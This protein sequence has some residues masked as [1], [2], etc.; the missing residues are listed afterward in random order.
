MSV[1]RWTTHGS[2][3][4]FSEEE[5]EK[6][7]EKEKG[8]A[9]MDASAGSAQQRASESASESERVLTGENPDTRQAQTI[10]TPPE[11]ADSTA[12]PEQQMADSTV[13]P[14]QQM[15]DTAAPPEHADTAA[16]PEQAT[17]T[18]EQTDSVAT[19]GDGQLR[20]GVVT[21]WHLPQGYGFI[22]PD[23]PGEP[24]VWVSEKALSGFAEP[25]RHLAQGER[26]LYEAVRSETRG[27]SSAGNSAAAAGHNSAHQG[28]VRQQA[29]RVLPAQGRLHGVI[30]EYSFMH[31]YGGIVAD[32]GTR[33]FLHHSNIL[34]GPYRHVCE[35][36]HV[37]FFMHDE[38]QPGRGPDPTA[39][40]V[41]LGDPR[42]ALYRFAQFPGDLDRWL[43]PLAIK[44]AQEDWSYRHEYA[45]SDSPHPI[46]RRYIE[47]TFE[48]LL[49]E[50]NAG[51][52]TILEGVEPSGRRYA[53]FNTGL[54]NE[55]RRP[56]YALFDELRG[57]ADPRQWRWR[58]FVTDDEGPMGQVAELPAPADYL[59]DPAALRITPEEARAMRVDTKHIL[60]DN[61]NRFPA[62]LRAD[63]DLARQ[64][65]EGELHELPD[66]IRRNYRLAV[67]VYYRGSIHLALPLHLS[68]A[69]RA[70]DL[71]LVIERAPSGARRAGTVL[72]KDHVYRQSRVLARP[73]A[74]WLSA[75]WLAR[76][77]P[78]PTR[79]G[80]RPDA[81]SDAP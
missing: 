7:K 62:H 22:R 71:A 38:A 63:P 37:F 48:R 56:I 16:T 66:R 81:P 18:P 45:G 50:R 41:K 1:L 73:E 14:E 49:E 59:S 34:G 76:K 25:L 11:P 33:Y 64:V 78:S 8:Q 23:D 69:S 4:E 5:E 42:A 67:P 60:Q 79:P 52:P 15:T 61:L 40:A 13:P 12:P 53:I 74:D 80:K 65:L 32:D 2:S 77:K 30:D 3:V 70:P 35:G 26:V 44:A 51:R 21:F 27:H 31:G 75:A 43:E 36:D 6:E 57:N 68:G 55:M 54:V 10:P 24:D 17:A 39:A 29:V 46:L 28:D 47:A 19:S 20:A 9:H 72:S 58:A